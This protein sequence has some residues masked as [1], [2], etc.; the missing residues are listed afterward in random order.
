[1]TS[2]PTRAAVALLAAIVTLSVLAGAAVAAVPGP[3][4]EDISF[5]ERGVTA[6]AF[7]ES[8]EDP[9]ADGAIRCEMTQAYV[10]D[11]RQRSA[12]AFGRANASRTYLCVYHQQATL[13]EEGVPVEPPLIEQGCSDDPQLTIVARL[14]SLTASVPALVLTEELCT[15]DPETGDVSCEPGHT[16]TVAVEA[17]FTGV[18]PLASDRWSSKSRTLVDGVR[19]TFSSSGSGVRRDA[20]ATIRID[21][22]ALE[23]PAFAQLSDGKN[24]F[25]QRCN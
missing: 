11:G 20:T 2:H 22:A 8:C 1:M 24:R 16:R 10:F 14:A 7:W 19:C 6:Q 17:A 15:V 21:G 23:S 5:V 9:D 25:A 12:D 4:P 3:P 13:D 18:G